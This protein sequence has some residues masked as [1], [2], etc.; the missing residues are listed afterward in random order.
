MIN[1]VVPGG[2]RKNWFF[3]LIFRPS[4]YMGKITVGIDQNDVPLNMVVMKHLD[5]RIG[6]EK[7][8]FLEFFFFFFV[9]FGS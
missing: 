1:P 3:Q 4:T 2:K 9:L 7:N 8:A 5:L 6:H